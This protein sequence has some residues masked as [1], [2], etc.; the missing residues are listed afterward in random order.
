MTQSHKTHIIEWL[1][2]RV[3]YM[4]R[5]SI[6]RIQNKLSWADKDNSG[7]DEITNSTRQQLAQN[8]IPTTASRDD[9]EKNSDDYTQRKPIRSFLSDQLAPDAN[10]K[11][12]IYRWISLDDISNL[13]EIIYDEGMSTDKS[14]DGEICFTSWVYKDIAVKYAWLHNGLSVIF[15]IPLQM[16]QDNKIPISWWWDK[17]PVA[18][19]IPPEIIQKWHIFLINY[20]HN[21]LTQIDLTSSQSDNTSTDEIKNIVQQENPEIINTPKD[22]DPLNNKYN[23]VH[24]A[25]TGRKALSHWANRIPWGPGSAKIGVE[26]LIGRTLWWEKLSVAQRKLYG[27]WSALSLLWW[28]LWRLGIHTWNLRLWLPLPILS[29]L[30]STLVAAGQASIVWW[31]IDIGEIFKT[32]LKEYTES[33]KNA[34]DKIRSKKTDQQTQEQIATVE[35]NIQH[36]E[37]IVQEI[38][39]EEATNIVHEVIIHLPEKQDNEQ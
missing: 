38:T 28:G 19:D 31:D 14:E 4:L 11:T 27:L 36:I 21:C 33:A 7:I 30:S 20:K 1:Y 6:Q 17:I 32:K 35:A 29:I 34:I 23:A 22:E 12:Y 10:N 2:L 39:N 16:I 18:W 37:N 26:S 25:K 24:I 3:L 5:S 13:K 9:I 8:T 15:Q